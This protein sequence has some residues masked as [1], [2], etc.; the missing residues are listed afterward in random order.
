MTLQGH[1]RS[2][3]LAPIESAYMTSY[4]GPQLA[5]LVLSCC[6]SEILERLYAESRFSIPLSYSGQ[7]FGVF[8]LFPLK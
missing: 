7:N 4:I 2:L 1:S 3:I 5:T 6:I 8:P